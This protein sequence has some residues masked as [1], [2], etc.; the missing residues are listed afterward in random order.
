MNLS[1][2]NYIMNNTHCNLIQK[3][4]FKGKYLT[5]KAF[6]KEPEVL[7]KIKTLPKNVF[8]EQAEFL[9]FCKSIDITP[10]I[11]GAITKRLAEV[12]QAKTAPDSAIKSFIESSRRVIEGYKWL[13]NN[14]R[15]LSKDEI[16]VVSKI[17]LDA[18]LPQDIRNNADELLKKN[19]KII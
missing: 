17:S 2:Q 1:V 12:R 10:K 19:A 3:T 6:A 16:A 4:A 14:A 18:Q 11:S 13:S 8:I 5:S 9:K 15:Q 7:E